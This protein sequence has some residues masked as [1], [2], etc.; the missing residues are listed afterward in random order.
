MLQ[1]KNIINSKI[2][3]EL[4]NL[5]MTMMTEKGWAIPSTDEYSCIVYGL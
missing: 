4:A 1:I 5:I 2:F 3:K